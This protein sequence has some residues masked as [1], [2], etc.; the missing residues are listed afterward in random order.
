MR[1]ILAILAVGL[2]VAAA[3]ADAPPPQLAGTWGGRYLIARFSVDIVQQGA[4]VFGLARVDT[5]LGGRW[6]YH[7]DGRVEGDRVTGRHHSGHRFEGRLE[8][9]G[10]IAGVLT[11]RH[12]LTFR[13][14]IRRKP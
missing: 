8:A 13:V 10:R 5:P 4:E 6:T 9:D 11:T 7:L 1:F 2:A 3:A 12:G 14:S